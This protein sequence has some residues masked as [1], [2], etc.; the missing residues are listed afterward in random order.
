MK[1]LIAIE[2]AKISSYSLF[3]VI[4]ILNTV[5]FLLVVFVSSRINVNVPG[6]S[7]RNVYNFPN[8]W[9][10]L[11][12]VASWFN[13][14]LAI[15]VMVFTGNEF[16]NRTFRQQVISGLSRN[17][18]LAGK[19]IM[20]AGV[21]LYGMILVSL[22]SLVYGIIFTREITLHVV[23]ENTGILLVYFLQAVGYM[24][25]AILFI[26]VLR[27]TSL[28]IILYIL[29]FIIMEPVAR[30]LCPPEARLWFPVKIIS[31]LTPVPEFLSI[32]SQAAGGDAAQLTY[33]S[34][35]LMSRQLPDGVNLAMAFLYI[36]IFAFLSWLA[37]KKKDL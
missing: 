21:A 6:F 26:V 11:A 10:G 7:W 22:T 17:E 27:S 8:V 36:L 4:L 23:F 20:I 18:W 16:A 37:V 33:E 31:H 13:V 19:G 29:Y 24:V 28:S 2:W 34:I 30:L 35:G 14:L 32:T 5:F 25:L 12:W 1:R 3:R 9:S 15:M